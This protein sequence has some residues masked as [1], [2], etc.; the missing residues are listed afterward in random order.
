MSETQP[1]GMQEQI[2]ENLKT[3]ILQAIKSPIPI[4]EHETFQFKENPGRINCK[5][6]DELRQ[7]III[8]VRQTGHFVHTTDEWIETQIKHEEEH[9]A[10]AKK[11]WGEDV[12]HNYWIQFL[13]CDGTLAFV[14]GYEI[15]PNTKK[16][17]KE[18]IIENGVKIASAP[19]DLSEGDKKS[20]KKG[21]TTTITTTVTRIF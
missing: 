2:H 7:A 4:T 10:E 8:T 9:V 12:F 16:Y 19:E 5:N 6:I 15:N 17:T 18:Q 14:P 20:L 13:D 3:H 1:L 11:R 21:T